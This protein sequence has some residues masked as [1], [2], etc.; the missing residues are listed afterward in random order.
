MKCSA[1]TR[2][3]VNRPLPSGVIFDVAA[4]KKELTLL[5]EQIS[6]PDFWSQ[7]ERSQKMMQ[8]RKR[9]EEAIGNDKW[10]A[11]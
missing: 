4:K 2:R 1:N 6:Q 7:P 8:D 9:L 3:S 10:S 11:P 5:E